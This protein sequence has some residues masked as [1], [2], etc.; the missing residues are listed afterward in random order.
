[1]SFIVFRICERGHVQLAGAL[2]S[3]ERLKQHVVSLRDLV[4]LSTPL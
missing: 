3:Y 4:L 2:G 1:M